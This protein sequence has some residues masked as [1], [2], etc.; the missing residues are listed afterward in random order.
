MLICANALRIPLADESVQCVVTSPP[1]WGLR[2]YAGEQEFIWNANACDHSFTGAASRVPNLRTGLGME[3]LGKKHRGG[4]KKA[5]AMCKHDWAPSAIDKN[6]RDYQKGDSSKRWNHDPTAGAETAKHVAIVLG[7]TCTK[8][9]AWRGAFGLEPT[10]EMYVDHTIQILREIRRVLRKDG[11]V[12]WNIGDSYCSGAYSP[13]VREKPE[14]TEAREK[15]RGKDRTPH[16]WT[17]QANKIP[18]NGRPEGLKPKDLVLMPARIA[19]AAQADG[20]WVRSM[21]IWAK[22]NPMPESVT[23]RPTDSYEHIIVLV[24]GQRRTQ[25]TMFSD[26]DPEHVHFSRDL[27][28][29]SSCSGTS[30]LCVALA[31]SVFNAA[32][33][34]NDFSFPPFYSKEWKKRANGKCSDFVMRLPSKHR[35]AAHAARFLDGQTSTKEFLCELHSIGFSL[36][37]TDHLLIRRCLT[38]LDSPNVFVDS[39]GSV[40][41][42]D[43]GKISKVDFAHGK[44]VVTVPTACNY[45]W[46]ADA[47]REMAFY[48]EQGGYSSWRGDRTMPDETRAFGYTPKGTHSRGTGDG[49]PKARARNEEGV[50]VGWT[51]S[52]RAAMVSRNMRNVWMFATQPYSGAHFATFPE[53][54]PRRCIKAASSEFGACRFCGA[55]WKRISKIEIAPHPNRWSKEPNAGQF[56]KDANEYR[57]DGEALGMAT[58]SKTIG[59]SPTCRCKGQHRKVVP[60]IVLD[61]FGGSGTTGRVAIELN[62]TPVLLD[63]AYNSESSEHYA[64]LARKRTTEV[65]RGL[66]FV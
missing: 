62:R 56:N 32:Q 59:W 37:K 43:A 41:V 19:L 8:C 22:A 21:I 39:D 54:L 4:G 2:R 48:D 46:D 66:S 25:A 45:F 65:Q 53:E 64:D 44:I 58:Q 1:Y 33:H 36:A 34:E 29:Q 35:L 6:H 47:V 26:L 57:F 3:K 42:N 55:P 40:A 63:V 11:V 7:N 50:H 27:G 14:T 17:I 16:N 9:G 38:E 13:R 5:T 18:R 49:G 52:T 23:D 31:T 30:A 60:S 28:T 24:K 61:P 15:K 12:F 20:W 10:V 51:E